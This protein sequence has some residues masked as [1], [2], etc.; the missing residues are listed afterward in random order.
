LAK[1]NDSLVSRFRYGHRTMLLPGDAEKQVER[2][3]LS[4]NGGEALHSDVLKVGHHGSKNST[5]PEFLAAVQPRFAIISAGEFN[6]YGHPHA[7]LL[8]RLENAGTV[9]LRTD[10]DGAVHV[11]TDGGWR[12][13]AS[14]RAPVRQTQGHHCRRRRQITSKTRRRNKNPTPACHS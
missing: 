1:N 4:E 14:W 13:P 11:L 10:S 2:E 7:E 8:D 5:I 9:I 12:L 3:M 6:P